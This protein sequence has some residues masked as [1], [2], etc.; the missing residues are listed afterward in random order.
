MSEKPISITE[1][2]GAREEPLHPKP[3]SPVPPER[4]RRVSE[5]TRRLLTAAVLIPAV[6][7]VIIAGGF[8]YL[9]AVVAIVV[10]GLYELYRLIE[11]KGAKPITGFGLA[12]GAAL[13]VVAYVGSDYHVTLLTTATLLAVMIVQLGKAQ[14]SEAL[15]SISGTFFGVFYV[16]WLLSHAVGLREFHTVV[17]K[18]YGP[19]AAAGVPSEVGIFYMVFV[20][21]AVVAS[22]AGAYFA[23]RAYGRRKLAPQISPKKTVEGA[24]GGVL[25][26]LA[27]GLI[28][29]GVFDFF[30]PPLSAGLSWL[31]IALVAPTLAVFAILGD[32]IESLLKRDADRKDVGRLLPGMGGL[33]DR[34]DSS[35]LAIPVLYYM[36][37]F[38]TYLREG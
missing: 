1:R 13:P 17:A 14:I 8:W 6:V 31:S 25:A 38:M 21:S 7:T 22:D 10:I 4:P 16:G 33:L 34:I 35:L 37:V 26:G 9:G 2:E 15:A 3:P 32:L 20:V 29:K 11:A 27:A 18:R 19:E 5:L 12:A 24:I 28:V 30:W 36:L 23:G